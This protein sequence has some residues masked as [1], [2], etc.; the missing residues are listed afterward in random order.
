MK[1]LLRFTVYTLFACLP[2]LSVPTNATAEG[3]AVESGSSAES[4]L[5][6]R[7]G[8]WNNGQAAPWDLHIID[9]Y[10][11]FGFPERA[12]GYAP[13]QPIPF[14]HKFH[15]GELK[16]E[17]QFCHWTV[18]KAAFAAIPEV[19]TC[20]GCHQQ[21]VGKQS[22]PLTKLKEYWNKGEPIPW[23]KVHVMPDHVRFNHKRHVKAGVTCQ[24]CHGQVPQMEVVE[25]ASSMKMG[26]CIDCHRQ[27][28]ASID[29]WVCHK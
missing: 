18:T 11:Y 14:S 4:T 2:L 3:G 27:R 1:S 7:A 21:L 19:E 16:M 28:G 15:V 29:C 12:R 26:W 22:E 9:H 8:I 13:E 25:R 10:R 23:E 5:D 20:M 6:V 24:E 17:C